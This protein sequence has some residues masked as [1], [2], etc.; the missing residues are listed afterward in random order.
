MQNEFSK[1]VFLGRGRRIYAIEG[2]SGPFDVTDYVY[3]D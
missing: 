1:P 3:G 2:D